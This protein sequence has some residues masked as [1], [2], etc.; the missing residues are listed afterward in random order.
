MVLLNNVYIHISL[1][2]GLV[3]YHECL[4]AAVHQL[5]VAATSGK[6]GVAGAVAKYSPKPTDLRTCGHEG[7]ERMTSIV[8][9]EVGP[10][11]LPH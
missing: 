7:V 3:S 11:V 2:D 10:Q 6:I 9:L 4:V 1:T 8:V 5:S